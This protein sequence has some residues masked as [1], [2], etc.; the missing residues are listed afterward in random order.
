MPYEVD[1]IGVKDSKHDA[2]AI[3]IRWWSHEKSR[4]IVGVIDGGFKGHGEEL[5]RIIE[6]Y[7]FADNNSD[8]RC[9]DFIICTHSDNDHTEGIKV[10]L[11]NYNV[12]KI[13]INLPWRYTDELEQYK[14]DG[15]RTIDSI[16]RHLK[17][18]YKSVVDI[19]NIAQEKDVKILPIF[20]GMLIENRLYVLS[21]SKDFYLNLL[22]E[23]PK[24]IYESQEFF[25][26]SIF[27]S[28]VKLAKK[29]LGYI[30]SI[31][32]DYSVETLSEEEKTT[33]ENEMSTVIYGCMEEENFLITGDAGVR[34]LTIAMDHADENIPNWREK[35]SWYQI[36]HHGSRH[37][38]TP[39]IMNRMIGDIGQ[40]NTGKIAFVC[41]ADN[42]VKKHPLKVV[43]NAY[44]RRGI[45][46][47]NA[48]GY[49]VNHHK[50]IHSRE[51]WSSVTEVPFSN[52]VE[53]ISK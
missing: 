45:K 43:T 29:A 14:D 41:S 7:Y 50:G 15:R 34:A 25:S 30:Y 10:V 32:E 4:Y 33:A 36:P 11:K 53:E 26:G 23:S 48:S 27:E 28:A 49:T 52:I 42:A 35:I 6:T 20:Q 21:P 46:V 9:I 47:I 40:E 39:S 24:T 1:F 5:C 51:G 19:E 38:I 13:Y 17:E 8:E 31:V 44:I 12:K 3:G 18:K 16:N 37:N 2:D 22:R